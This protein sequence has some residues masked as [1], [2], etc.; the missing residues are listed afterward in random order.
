M[1]LTPCLCLPPCLCPSF[2]FPIICGPGPA[3]CTP[4]LLLRSKLCLLCPNPA[5]QLSPPFSISTTTLAVPCPQTLVLTSSSPLPCPVPDPPFSHNPASLALDTPLSP[6]PTLHPSALAPPHPQLKGV[7]RVLGRTTLAKRRGQ[8]GA[9][10]SEWSWGYRG[11]KGYEL[12]AGI[13]AWLQREGCK[14][15]VPTGGPLGEG[16]NHV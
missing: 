1:S 8:S 14:S 9:W 12:R 11:W 2:W 15:G 4:S 10:G 7:G 5:P 16:W 6:S 13:G 3:P